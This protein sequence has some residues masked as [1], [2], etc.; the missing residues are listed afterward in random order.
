MS[1][2][3]MGVLSLGVFIVIGAVCM[4]VATSYHLNPFQTISLIISFFGVW[5]IG[6]GGFNAVKRR[7]QKV[8]NTLLWGVLITAIG[9]VCFLRSHNLLV[10]YAFP[11][12]MLV[13]GILIVVTGLSTRFR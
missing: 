7:D 10:G 8:T 9:S 6:V 3:N 1:N 11:V 13:L 4:V 12:L 5:I 2:R